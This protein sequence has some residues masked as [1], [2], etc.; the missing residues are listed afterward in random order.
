M[1]EAGAK[2]EAHVKP[3]ERRVELLCRC[4]VLLWSLMAFAP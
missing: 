2:V 4:C 3:P 1:A